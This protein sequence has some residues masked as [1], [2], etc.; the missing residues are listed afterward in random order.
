ML[1]S[2]LEGSRLWLAGQEHWPMSELDYLSPEQ[3][4]QGAFVDEL[5]DL[6]S[7]G[8]V[9]YG[10]L[11]GRPPFVAETREDLI[12]QIQGPAKPRGLRSLTTTFRA[13]WKRS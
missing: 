9:V 1:G 11:T 4:A 7:L 5:S 8:A 10:L 13:R 12:E 3:T 2:A 6:Y